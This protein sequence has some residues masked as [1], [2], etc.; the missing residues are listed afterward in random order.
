MLYQSSPTCQ[1]KNEQNEFA[2]LDLLYPKVPPELYRHFATEFIEKRKPFIKRAGKGE[3]WRTLNYPL[4]DKRVA[5]HF[6]GQYWIG[7]ASGTWS[8][9]LILDIDKHRWVSQ[10][11]LD[12]KTEAALA[13]FSAKP[14]AFQSSD[15]GGRHLF[16][17]VEQPIYKARLRSLAHE[18][19][20]SAGLK[21]PRDIE[22]FPAASNEKCLRLPLGARSYLLNDHL[23]PVKLNTKDALQRV[24]DDI[25]HWP[26]A[27]L[28]PPTIPTN[29]LREGRH[30]ARLDKAVGA[31]GKLTGEE[32]RGF[33]IEALARG[34]TLPSSRTYTTLKLVWYHLG[35]LNLS[36]QET[37]FRLKR[38]L[39]DKHNGLSKDYP[40]KA[41]KV[42]RDLEYIIRSCASY[43]ATHARPAGDR[44]QARLTT[45]DVAF[46]LGWTDDYRLQQFLFA[47]L[48]YFKGLGL[49]SRVILSRERIIQFRG[50][51][52]H[53][54][55]AQ[56]EK[57]RVCGLT[58]P[59]RIPATGTFYSPPWDKGG[60][61]LAREWRLN[62]DFRPGEPVY[63]LEEGIT[64]EFS[65]AEIRQKYTWWTANRILQ[66][67]KKDT[68]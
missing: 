68:P 54:Y 24:Y 3:T 44:E 9:S 23:E 10:G 45:G 38:W 14:L 46:I 62:Y 48:L 30:L 32:F 13:A 34:L 11:E 60:Y 15:S 21:C 49:R 4:N 12:E 33:C 28:F 36:E 6:N 41:A 50:C 58:Y 19:L 51:S 27:F 42:V 64:V 8:R 22:I 65:E 56:V 39:Q 37:L 20:R 67:S 31:G 18:R 26:V 2:F 63:S 52:I 17:F 57:L 25:V 53:S 61:G 47:W 35:S 7:V 55:R 66:H 40:S 29:E 43:L 1:G 5:E 59:E 16:W